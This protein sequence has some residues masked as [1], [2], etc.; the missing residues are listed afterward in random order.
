MS[1][2]PFSHDDNLYKLIDCPTY[3]TKDHFLKTFLDGN[4]K[5]VILTAVCYSVIKDNFLSIY[6]EYIYKVWYVLPWGNTLQ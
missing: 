6:I 3:L 1:G 2:G 4:G 5:W